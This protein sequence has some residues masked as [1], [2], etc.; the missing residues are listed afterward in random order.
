MKVYEIAEKQTRYVDSQWMASHNVKDVFARYIFD[1][2]VRVH[3]CELTPSVE[4]HCVGYFA[5]FFDNA[6]DDDLEAVDDEMN[7]WVRG[8]EY[9]KRV[10]MDGGMIAGPWEYDDL[11][12]A[13]D[14]AHVNPSFG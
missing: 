5:E 4:L 13:I 10:R 9:V 14:D 3:C 6:T 2:E 8:V 11:E 7:C 1:D 12:D